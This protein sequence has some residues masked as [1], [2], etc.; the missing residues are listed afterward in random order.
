[1]SKRAM[2]T[3]TSGDTFNYFQNQFSIEEPT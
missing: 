1:M 2:K 3:F